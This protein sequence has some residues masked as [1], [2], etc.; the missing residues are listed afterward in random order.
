[1]QALFIHGMGR[2]PLSGWPL[3]SRLRA[4]GIRVTSFAYIA[5][6]QDFAQISARL[7]ARIETLAR[8]DDYVLIGHSLGGVLV[9]SALAELPP[10]TRPPV[11]VFLL[12]SPIHPSRLAVRFQRN[13]LY[14]LITGDCGQLLAC[15]ERM[16]RIAPVASP[17]I[18]II[19]EHT[20]RLTSRLFAGEINDGIVS[21]SET[22]A[23]WI[24]EELRVPVM[25]SFLP[26]NSLVAEQILARIDGI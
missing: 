5:A 7:A 17:T 23:N 25:H 19:G 2:S 9:R 20:I 14:R 12:G 15:E 24:G 16:S 8:H 11:R 13:P 3:M 10:D 4:S 1:M 21:A 6:T 18:A 26:G 22:R